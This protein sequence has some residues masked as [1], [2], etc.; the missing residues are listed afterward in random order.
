[1][2]P[3]A[4]TSAII[5]ESFALPSDEH[6]VAAAQAGDPIA[7]TELRNRHW[8][9]TRR[10]LY[11]ITRNW[12]DADDALQDCFLKVFTHLNGFGNRCSFGTWLTSIAINSGLTILRKRRVHREIPIDRSD[13]DLNCRSTWEL[14]DHREDPEA[15]CARRERE[16]LL[17]RAILRLSPDHR[18]L[19]E[20]QEAREYSMKELSE[21]LGITMP[22]V[23][24]RLLRARKAL[25]TS[26]RGRRR[27]LASNAPMKQAN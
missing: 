18:M 1:M 10:L 3:T 6:L 13:D 7:F 16:E 23:K 9:R 17:R 11:R 25:R 12:D 4:G 8:L 20:L 26:L 19:L 5:G 24:S 2:N 15:Y 27:S 21:C 14:R 22:A